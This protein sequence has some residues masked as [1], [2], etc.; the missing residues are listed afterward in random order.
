MKEEK[1][2]ESEEN[3]G[4]K[5][6]KV[7]EGEEKKRLVGENFF[8]T[9]YKDNMDVVSREDLKSVFEKFGTVKSGYIRFEEIE[10]AQKARATAVISEKDG[11]IVKNYIAII[12]PVIEV[13]L[14]SLVL[15]SLNPH[16]LLLWDI[17]NGFVHFFYDQTT[18]T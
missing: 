12:D 13:P 5:E 8:A 1:E 18:F 14:V 6:G 11:L 4:M 9:A 16:L 7:T 17:R 2:I 10:S 15:M 3:N